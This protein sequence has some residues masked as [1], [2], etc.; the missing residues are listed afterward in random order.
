MIALVTIIAVRHIW[1]AYPMI[2]ASFQQ[3]CLRRNQPGLI[4]CRLNVITCYSACAR[5]L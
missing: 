5:A 1:I 3:P 2:I 4:A